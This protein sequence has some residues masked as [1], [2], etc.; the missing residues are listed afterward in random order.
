MLML[1]EAAKIGEKINIGMV[2]SECYE[3]Q[4]VKNC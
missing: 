3:Y 4:I 2:F 1:N